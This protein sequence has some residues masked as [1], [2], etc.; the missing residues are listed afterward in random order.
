[1][2]TLC[3]HR[4]RQVDGVRIATMEKCPECKNV[5]PHNT[6]KSERYKHRKSVARKLG[7]KFPHVLNAEGKQK[8]KS[9][10]QRRKLRAQRNLTFI[11]GEEK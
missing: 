9:G 10:S 3:E 7:W 11:K 1:M 2:R 5:Q 8:N 4:R 6:R